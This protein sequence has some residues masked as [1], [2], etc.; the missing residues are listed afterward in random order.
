MAGGPARRAGRSSSGQ[1]SPASTS[2]RQRCAVRLTYSPN[3]VR[4]HFA[5]HARYLL[6][7]SAAGT[8]IVSGTIADKGLAETMQQWQEAGDKRVFKVILSP[9]FGERIDLGKLSAEFI[10]RI[11]K[12]FATKLEWA[13]VSHHNTDHPHVHLVMRGVDAKGEE[14]RFPAPYIQNTL[15]AHAEALCTEQIGTRS[16]DDVHHAQ[17]KEVGLHRFTSLD[18]AILK[19]AELCPQ[20]AGQLRVTVPENR[21][22]GANQVNELLAARLRFLADSGLAL[23][24]TSSRWTI[25]IDLDNT[26][27]NMQNVADRQRMLARTGTAV[28]DDRLPQRI[29]AVRDIDELRGRVLGHVENEATGRIYMVLEGT[30]ATIH[31][32]SHNGEIERRRSQGD[33]KPGSLVLLSLDG[34][35][36]RIEDFGSAEAVLASQRLFPALPNELPALNGGWRGWL[37]AFQDRLQVPV[38]APSVLSKAIEGGRE[39]PDFE[40]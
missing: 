23:A 2:Y 3:R 4:G 16:L 24:E 17:R 29:T 31:F 37:G 33:L 9:E 20:D 13:A 7:D 12:D 18:R 15:R 30:D 39:R 14:F 22:P 8:G 25:P 26:L 11:E 40:R 28:S 34:Q 35:K 36:L 10:A 38:S 32:L 21:G 27:R 1:H 5:A 6:R 19:R